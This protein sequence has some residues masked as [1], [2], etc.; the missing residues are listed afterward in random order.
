METFELR[1]GFAIVAWVLNL[2]AVRVGVE[3]F[4]PHIDANHAARF[5]VFAFTLRLDTELDIVAIGAPH[6]ANPLD[7]LDWE[8]FDVLSWVADQTQATTKGEGDLASIRFELPPSWF[9]LH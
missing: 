5:N 7:L 2:L 4:Q 1:L 6:D 9:I 8:G 3:D